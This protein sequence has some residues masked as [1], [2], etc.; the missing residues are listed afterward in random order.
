V[1]LFSNYREARR[2]AADLGQCIREARCFLGI[3]C[4]SSRADTLRNSG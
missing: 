1:D 3:R 2:V 4:V